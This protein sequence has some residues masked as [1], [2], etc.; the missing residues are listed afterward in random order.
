M[1]KFNNIINYV[2]DPELES[3]DNAEIYIWDLWD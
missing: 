3:D 1:I 2:F